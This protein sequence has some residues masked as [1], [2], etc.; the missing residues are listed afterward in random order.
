MREI[1]LPHVEVD[2]TDLSCSSHILM[3]LKD[4]VEH[5][6]DKRMMS[7]DKED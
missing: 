7:F 5:D 2:E 4:G 3:L 1:T 6:N